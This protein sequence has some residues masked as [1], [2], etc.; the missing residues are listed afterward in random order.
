MQNFKTI[1]Q[2]LLGELAMSPEERKKERERKNAIYSGHLRLCQQP[3]APPALCSDQFS[4]LWTFGQEILQSTLN[5]TS[6]KELQISTKGQ[7][8]A[9]YLYSQYDTLVIHAALLLIQN[10]SLLPTCLPSS[11]DQTSLVTANI[12]L[13]SAYLSIVL[14]SGGHWQ[15]SHC[16]PSYE[17]MFPPGWC[18]VTTMEERH[19]SL[20]TDC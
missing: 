10:L 18:L 15:V 1:Q 13:V 20:D 5:L 16:I 2:F 11:D 14:V 19:S 4:R 7:Q 17:Q 3:R 12:S 6:T 8:H 9:P